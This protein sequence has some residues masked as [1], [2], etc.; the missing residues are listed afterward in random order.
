[1]LGRTD[2]SPLNALGNDPCGET[3]PCGNERDSKDMQT[4]RVG[5]RD[6]GIGRRMHPW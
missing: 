6:R 2:F 1:M 5:G 4:E 3:L